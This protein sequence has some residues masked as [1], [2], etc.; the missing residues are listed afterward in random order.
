VARGGG[1]D[2]RALRRAGSVATF[3]ATLAAAVLV[4]AA[5]IAALRSESVDAATAPSAP[6]DVRASARD[7]AA[8]VSWAPPADDGGSLVAGYEVRVVETGRLVTAGAHE[9]S[10]TVDGLTNGDWYTFRVAASNVFG[11]GRAALTRPVVP[12]RPNIVLVL[13]DDQPVGTVAQM[14]ATRARPWLRFTRA[15]ANEPMCC[16]ARAT[17]LTGRYSHHTGVETNVDGHRLDD[18]QTLAT[19][20][21][22]VGYQTALVGKYLNGY[23]FGPHRRVPPGWDHW[24]VFDTPADYYEYALDVDG[25]RHAHGSEPIDYSTDVLTDHA[26]RLLRDADPTQP[27]FLEVAYNAPHTGVLYPN[28]AIPAPRHAGACADVRF[29]FP[30][31]FNASDAVAEPPWMREELP[32]DPIAMVLLRQ[33]TCEALRAVDEGVRDI[34]ATLAAQGRLDNTYLVYLSDNGFAYGEHRLLGKGD[35]YEPSVRI[36]L[37]VTGPGVRRGTTSRLTSNVDLAP[38]IVEWA[39]ASTPPGFTDG[40]SFAE[41]AAGEPELDPPAAVLLRG[42][43]GGGFRCEATLSAMGKNW[44]VRTA[45]WKYVVYPDG[46]RQ[47]FDL[48]ADPAELRNLAGDRAHA[49]TVAV[50]HELM[51]RLRTG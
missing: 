14:P 40:D 10:V 3:G 22:A 2:G 16:P 45:R 23:P 5:G 1:G 4:A 26:T 20:L 13:T 7:G 35:L 42:C 30:R 21:D 32:E 11:A 41:H 29:G 33:A 39:R 38:T 47:L 18:T 43:R 9:R 19:W 48:A 15:F 6:R 49:P 51:V 25:V 27:V 36:P 44:G 28:T 8:V 31:S 34:V 24:V 50:L 17:I 37:L 12:T 46:S